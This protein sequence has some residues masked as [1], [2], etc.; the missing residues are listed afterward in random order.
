MR[1]SRGL[2]ESA[3]TLVLAADSCCTADSVCGQLGRR[4]ERGDLHYVGCA[5]RL[6][7]GRFSIFPAIRQPRFAC[8]HSFGYRVQNKPVT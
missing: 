8:A 2:L 1:S 5:D 4:P 6:G 7:R 3:R